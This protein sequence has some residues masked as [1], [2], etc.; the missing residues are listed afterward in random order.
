MSPTKC[1]KVIFFLK[2]V[3]VNFFRDFGLPRN[4]ICLLNRNCMP[5]CYECLIDQSGHKQ[6]RFK[7]PCGMHIS[8]RPV[9]FSYIFLHFLHSKWDKCCMFELWR[10]KRAKNARNVIKRI[11]LTFDIMFT[12]FFLVETMIKE[13]YVKKYSCIAWIR[14][15]Y[16]LSNNLYIYLF[17]YLRS[18][19]WNNTQLL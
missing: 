6:Q 5:C 16:L 9:R 7:T 13:D 10:K 14:L 18:S 15:I 11:N 4:H 12:I 19:A 3:K 2:R 1:Y 8:T 17:M